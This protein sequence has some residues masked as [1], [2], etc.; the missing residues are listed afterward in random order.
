MCGRFAPIGP[1]NIRR[2]FTVS[3]ERQH[4]SV[5]LRQGSHE[6]TN[7]IRRFAHVLKQSDFPEF[8]L[9]GVTQLHAP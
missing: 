4:E 3:G 9:N 5:Q 6:L 7:R 2:L 8:R 1:Q